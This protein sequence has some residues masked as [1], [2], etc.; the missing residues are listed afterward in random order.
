MQKH[1]SLREQGY[2]LRGRLPWVIAAALVAGSACLWAPW[3]G[4][5]VLGAMV[6]MFCMGIVVAQQAPIWEKK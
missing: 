1:E 4:I 5:R 2:Y 6:Q 3:Q